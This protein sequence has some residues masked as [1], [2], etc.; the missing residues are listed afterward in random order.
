LV[1]GTGIGVKRIPGLGSVAIGDA[2]TWL[3]AGNP[4][5]LLLDL[6][7]DA[8]G[9]SPIGMS[10]VTRLS[11]YVLF[12]G[13]LALISVT[14]ASA[15]LR[16]VFREQVYERDPALRLGKAVR[17]SVRV[18][19]WP[20]IWKEVVAERGLNFR[21]FGRA[22]IAV[23][24]IGSFLPVALWGSSPGARNFFAVWTRGMGA[25]VA[26]LLLLCI[27]VRAATTITGER[28]RQ[29]LDGLL[30][31]PL[32]AGEIL[33]GKWLGCVAS[34]RWG[35]LWLGAIWGTGVLGGELH[36]IAL[37]M[38]IAAWWVYAT[39]LAEVGLWFSLSLE[40]SMRATV[41]TLLLALGLGFSYFISLPI[42]M[43]APNWQNPGWFVTYLNRFQL[44]LSPIVTLSWLLAFDTEGRFDNQGWELPTALAALACWTIGGAVLWALLVRRFRKRTCR[45]MVR[46]PEHSSIL[47]PAPS[48]P[49]SIPF[50]SEFVQKMPV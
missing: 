40:S 20:M 49:G 4:L 38:M 32:G 5:T 13:L 29:T 17:K 35:W 28:E 9:G 18:G 25:A 14:W 7:G 30:M 37:L 47:K 15:R 44:G 6:A 10:F 42:F 3:D 39:V 22:V 21:R 43:A 50:S 36:P 27:A 16:A 46:P 45:Q 2:F 1:I 48:E 24:V 8:M 34:I 26:C 41:L 23:L 31:T 19:H 33:F 12:H 11:G